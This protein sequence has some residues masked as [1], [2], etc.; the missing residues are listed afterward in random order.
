MAEFDYKETQEKLMLCAQFLAELDLDK[1]L[2]VASRTETVAPILDPTLY[3]RGGTQ[4]RLVTDVAQ[5]A[6]PLQKAWE[7][8]K[9]EYPEAERIRMERDRIAGHGA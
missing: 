6:K 1:F 2:D 7:K 8:F 9:E 4:L 3:L 5:A